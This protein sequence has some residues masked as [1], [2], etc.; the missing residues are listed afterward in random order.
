MAKAPP[1][2]KF[3]LQPQLHK[4]VVETPGKM[5]AVPEKTSD[6]SWS[7]GVRLLPEP[8]NDNKSVEY[9]AKS[10]TVAH[11]DVERSFHHNGHFLTC[12]D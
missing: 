3:R 5:E 2:Q 6:G 11:V 4:V 10:V 12:V 1:S 7:T 8:S 9:E